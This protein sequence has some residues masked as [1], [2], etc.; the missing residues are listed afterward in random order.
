MYDKTA[1]LVR[2]NKKHEEVTGYSSEELLGMSVLDFFAEE[3]KEYLL[4]RVQAVFTQGE[5]FAEAPVLTKNGTQV[6]YFFT[7]RLAVLNG[8]QYFLGVGLDISERKRAEEE[9]N[10][11]QVQLLQAQKMELV[12]QLAGG[13]AHDFNNM[14]GVIVGYADLALRKTDPAGPVYRS[15]EKILGAADRS[16]NLV[17]QLLAFARKQTIVPR[18]LNLNETVE[19][20]LRM[21]GRLIGE[22]IELIW[23]PGPNLSL[24]K[25]DP[26]QID[27]ILANL[28]VNSRDAISG[29]GKVI[30]ETMNIVLDKDYCSRHAGFLPGNY[31]MLAVSDDGSG[32]DQETKARLFEPFFTTKSMGKG[33]GLGLATVYGIVKQNEGF[34]NV[35][36]EPGQGTVFR[37]YLPRYI[38]EGVET[39]IKGSG[40]PST[41]G[42]N[43]TILLV[44]DE[45]IILEIGTA[46]LEELGY[47]VV[48]VGRSSEAIR[49]TETYA[50]E[51]HLLMTDVVM[52][53]M[54]GRE[55][56]ERVVSIKPDIKC[57]F[58]SGYTANV[59]THRGVLDEGVNFIQKPFSMQTL[60]AKVREVLDQKR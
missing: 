5:A 39:K 20:I 11:L 33:T 15:I 43:E 37:I 6:P 17:R 53:E 23:Q 1:K 41:Q 31:V 30:I 13:V 44:E 55:L 12:G 9:K 47:R 8:R 46:M 7:G 52:P 56:A 40:A 57:L 54:N 34:I 2:W 24:V 26:T 10:H 35:Y 19:N 28:C 50:G 3:R 42:R 4:S 14:L 27:Q 59:I 49:L 29:V 51:I 38:G 32:F 21:L 36:S 16:A 22:D 60:A 48:A 45:P 58:M 18:V 25:M